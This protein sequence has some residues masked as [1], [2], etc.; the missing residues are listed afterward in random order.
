MAVQ[1]EVF[2]NGIPDFQTQ[3]EVAPRQG[4]RIVTLG[5]E[6]LEVNAVRHVQDADGRFH[7][8]VDTRAIGGE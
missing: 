2:R 5:E 1:I 4:E 6:H 3:F 7:Y 8:Q